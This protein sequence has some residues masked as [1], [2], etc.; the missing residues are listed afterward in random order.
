MHISP[1]RVLHS[2]QSMVCVQT[3]YNFHTEPVTQCIVQAAPVKPVTL[4]PTLLTVLDGC[5]PEDHPSYVLSG[6]VK[7]IVTIAK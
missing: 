3:R 6:T 7:P 1:L 4:I 5:H 2:K